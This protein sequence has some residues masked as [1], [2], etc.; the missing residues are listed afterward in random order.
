MIEKIILDHLGDVLDVPVYMEEPTKKPN[1]YVVLRI[2]DTEK[3][4]HINSASFFIVSVSTSLLKASKLNLSVQK[5]IESL[6]NPSVSAC[7]LSGGGQDI[8]GQTKTYRYT[9]VFN[10][11]YTED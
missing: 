7:R 5:A 3:V 6:D 1:E 9:S 4:N 2:W 10:T 11:F 8:D